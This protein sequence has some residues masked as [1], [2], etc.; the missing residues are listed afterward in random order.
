MYNLSKYGT[1]DPIGNKLFKLYGLSKVTTHY[2]IHSYT[3]L[4][5]F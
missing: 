4:L 1:K 3:R 5:P 2:Y